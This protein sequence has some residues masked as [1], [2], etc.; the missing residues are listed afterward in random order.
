V[1]EQTEIG[2]LLAVPGIL[3]TLVLAPWI[4]HL[5]YTQE[6]MPAVDL[7]QWFILGCLGQVI[8]WPLGFVML[9]LGKGKW[10]IFTETTGRLFQLL[11]VFF[12]LDYMGLAGVAVMLPIS[13]VLYTLMVYMLTVRLSGFS[14]IPEVRGYLVISVVSA[15]MMSLILPLFDAEYRLF[16]GLILLPPIYIYSMRGLIKRI[17]V[18][19][20]IFQHVVRSAILR[21]VCGL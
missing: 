9:A 12:L 17:G 5:F 19:N 8:S 16:L 20:R 13:F 11:L 1:N 14:W 10:F 21:K 18:N 2:L 4:I 15:V 3:A 7:L 6:F